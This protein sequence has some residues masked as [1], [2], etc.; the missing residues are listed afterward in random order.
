MQEQTQEEQT[1]TASQQDS[2][3]EQTANQ[4]AI[5]LTRLDEQGL[6]RIETLGDEMR[7][8]NTLVTSKMVPE[9][10]NTAQ[11]LFAA[12]QLC[13]EL[14]LPVMS[15]IRQV[16]VV[17]G[18]PTLWGDTPLA[19]VR[20]SQLLVFIDEYLIDAEYNRI[21]VKNKN[22]KAEIFASVCE[23]QRKDGERREYVFTVDQAQAAGLLN[24][25]GPWKNYR[26]RMMQMKARGLA[27]KNE[28]SDVLMGVGMAEYDFDE[29]PGVRVRDVG[30]TAAEKANRV[31]ENID[32]NNLTGSDQEP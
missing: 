32:V 2:P 14:G 16:Y 3:P 27:L 18:S 1:G 13:R 19:I 17:N 20:R 29:I 21:S 9:S 23:I 28:F 24:K 26:S 10:L 31:F 30:D 25:N 12:R 6:V 4:K 22:L 7:V 5:M 8:C 11:K 15:A